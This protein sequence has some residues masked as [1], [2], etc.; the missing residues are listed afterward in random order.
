VS[1][2]QSHGQQYNRY[3]EAG[4]CRAP[5]SALFGVGHRPKRPDMV[6]VKYPGAAGALLSFPDPKIASGINPLGNFD[7]FPASPAVHRQ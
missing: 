3:C 4:D 2:P 1:Q 6:E 5:V 7:G